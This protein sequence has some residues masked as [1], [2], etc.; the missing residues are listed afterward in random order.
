MTT[1]NAQEILNRAMSEVYA[2]NR[3][4]FSVI[5]ELDEK[6]PP[7]S[8]SLNSEDGSLDF[9]WLVPGAGEMNLFMYTE[10]GRQIPK[11][12][13]YVYGTYPRFYKEPTASLFERKLAI[14]H[15]IQGGDGVVDP[16]ADP[17][18]DVRTRDSEAGEEEVG[19]T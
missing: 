2:H 6:V 8:V 3:H 18:D 15:K 4:I 11:L 9:Q 16:Y 14:L 5:R 19:G 12:C 7:P 10:S 13:F 1:L 17:E